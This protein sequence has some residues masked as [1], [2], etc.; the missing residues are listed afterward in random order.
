MR[1]LTAQEMQQVDAETIARVCPGL[2]LM[3]RAGRGVAKAILTRHGTGAGDKH[4]AVV[5]CGPGNN[6]GDGF[7]VARYL[8]EAGWSCSIHLLKPAADLTPDSSKNYQR[9]HEMKAPAGALTEFDSTRPDWPER[10]REDVADGTI[11]IDA[12]FGTGAAGAPRGR[13]A[14]MIALMN[15][16]HLP[17][18]PSTFPPAS[19][20]PPAKSPAKRCAPP[21][22]SPSARPRRASCSTPAARTRAS[23]R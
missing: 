22:R 10:A 11:L 7:V 19:T 14:E 21:I 3:E 18:S 17:S 15:A 4:K 20:P 5:F 23:C 12:I 16:R 9:L 2:E 13:A 6:G 1:V 8:I